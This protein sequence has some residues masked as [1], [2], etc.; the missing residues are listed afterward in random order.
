MYPGYGAH[1][2]TNIEN[3]LGPYSSYL[4]T[5]IRSVGDGVEYKNCENIYVS[6]NVPK[7]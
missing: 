6:I 4:S 2:H 1:V 5:Q 3:I 7:N